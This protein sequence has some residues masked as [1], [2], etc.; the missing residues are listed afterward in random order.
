MKPIKH[1]FLT[2]LTLTAVTSG[3]WAQTS[4][5]AKPAQETQ[6]TASAPAF[7]ASDIQA[8][9]D[10]LSAAQQQIQAL[11]NE[12]RRR[13]QAV[14]QAQTAASDAAA[15]ADAVQLQTVKQQ[16]VVGV[17]QN[18]VADLKSVSASAFDQATLKNAVLT[19]QEPASA[20]APPAEQVFNK[21]MESPITIR[22]RGINITPG[23]YSAAEFVH[24]SKALAADVSTPFNNLTMPGATQSHMGEFYG[25][26]RQSKATV[27]V[28]GREKNV[29]LSG[30]ISTDFLS[31]G[32]TSTATNTNGYTLR[33]RQAWAQAKFANGWSFVG[34]QMWSLV[35]E[36]AVGI[37]PDD[38]MGKTNDVPAQDGRRGIQRRFQLRAPVWHP[39]GQEP[40]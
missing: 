7:T 40:R 11:Q 20:S 38:D 21:Q 13:D 31:S 19:S 33:L 16:Q 8:L 14:Q 17:L 34:G 32:V 10:G 39:R 35:T 36:D 37:A 3:A 22:F 29:D 18:E 27:F 25:S 30:Y 9:K 12:L 24:R 23:G 4:T 26:G 2:V 6:A 28:E 5:A 1:L 15:K